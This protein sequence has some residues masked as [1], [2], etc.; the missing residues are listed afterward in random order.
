VNVST[1]RPAVA[2]GDLVD[3]LSGFAFKSERFAEAGDLPLVRIRDVKRGYSETFY[4]GE[5][6]ARYLVNNGDLLIGMDGEFNRERWQGGVALLNQRVCKLT[7]DPRRLSSDYLFHFLPKILK[8]IENRTPFATVKHLSSKDIKE[9]QIPLP[10]LGEQKRIAALLDK[11]NGL[12]RKRRESIEQTENLRD[13]LYFHNFGDPVR[14]D[15]GWLSVTVGQ[16]IDRGYILEVQDGNHGER[17][18]KVADFVASGIPFIT[19]NCLNNGLLNTAEAYKLDDS[20]LT[21]L[22]VGFSQGGDLLLSHK[23]TVGEV[24]VVPQAVRHLIL[25]PQVTYYRTGAELD[26][27][28]LSGTFR[29]KSFQTLLANAAEQSTRAYIGITK[30]REMSIIV[31]PIAVQKQF[32]LALDKTNRLV[33]EQRVHLMRLDLLFTSLQSRAFS[34]QL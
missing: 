23:G 7:A 18:P 11:V 2:L 30:Q 14:N 22:R 19:A 28:F 20:W 31:P 15:R 8:D 12:R 34:G 21:K 24:A 27:R 29:T 5:Y 3:I 33:A 9:I 26:A 6:D 1:P 10:S 13:A 32:S 25:S 4:S 17:H 16:A